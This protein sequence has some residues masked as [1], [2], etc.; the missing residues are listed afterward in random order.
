LVLLSVL[1]ACSDG[2]SDS[3]S[4]SIPFNVVVSANASLSATDPITMYTPEYEALYAAGLRGAQTAAPWKALN[5]T[6][7]TYDLT[8]LTNSYFGTSALAGYGFTH[9]LLNI[10]S[11]AVDVRSMPADIDTLAFNHADVKARY[12]ALI[13]QVAPYLNASVRYVSLGNEVDTYLSTHASEWS[14]YKELIEDARTYL[15]SLKPDVLVGV[16]TT[17]DGAS[18]TQVSD[19]ASLNQ[20]MDII[21]YTYYPLNFATMTARDPSTVSADM[22]AMVSLASGKPLVIQEWGYPSSTFV[23]GSEQ[24]QSAFIANTFAAWRQHGSDT[25]PFLSFFKRRDW[26]SSE[27]TNRAQGQTAGQPFYEFLCSLGLLTDDGTPKPAYQTLADQV[28]G[29]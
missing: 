15:K 14:A 28:G 3:R 25:I 10:P 22:A 20:N 1:V 7:T 5:P 27:C 12:R 4:S 17:F 19:V 13:D 18:S 9:I 24:R 21:I 16:T 11:I 8:M 2:G 23:S 29:I 26:T 6:G